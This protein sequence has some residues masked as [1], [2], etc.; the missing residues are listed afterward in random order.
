[1]TGLLEFDD[2]LPWGAYA[3]GREA[4]RRL[5]WCQGLPAGVPGM[6][7]LMILLRHGLKHSL[8]TPVDVTIWGLRLRLMPRGNMSETKLLY[9]PQFF[10]P[11][12]RSFLARRLHAG[13]T[14][15][16][17]GMNAGI[18][19][20]WAHACMHGEGRILA[21]EP[22]PEMRRRV[23]FNLAANGISN[24]LIQPTALSDHEG[25]ATLFLNTA[26][27]GE[28]TL[29]ADAASGAPDA[30]SELRVP[31][32]TLLQALQ[33]GGIERVDALKIDI[34][35]H[36]PAVLQHFMTHADDELL[37]RALITE[38]KPQTAP[39]LDRLLSA[40]GYRRSLSTRLNW[41]FER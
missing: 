9:G 39:E 21:V 28:N 35:G 12:E 17:V 23:G 24:V 32:T 41:V 38:Y 3:P 4:A 15:V 30:R 2:S 5:R 19:T 13:S 11:E 8:Q 27:R 22:D 1:M 6:Y 34:E 26:Q 33:S 10:D 14:F 18:Y 31:T 25:H 16:D 7:R 29:V 37:P 40:R 20:F 36:E